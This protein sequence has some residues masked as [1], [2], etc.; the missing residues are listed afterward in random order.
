VLWWNVCWV[1]G[2][3]ACY[4]TACY[5]TAFSSVTN[6]FREYRL[7]GEEATTLSQFL[8]QKKP[9]LKFPA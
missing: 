2:S 5:T 4:P 3:P 1:Y 9:E 7:C 8:K 6:L